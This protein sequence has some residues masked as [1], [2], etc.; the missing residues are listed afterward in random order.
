MT[1]FKPRTSGVGNDRWAT[2]T[3]HGLICSAKMPFHQGEA[4]FES[5][6]RILGFHNK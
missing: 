1:V 3:A 6:V 4:C 5:K 2:T